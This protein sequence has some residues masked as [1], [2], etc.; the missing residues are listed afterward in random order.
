L[1][2]RGGSKERKGGREGGREGDILY[3][4]FLFT[5][6]GGGRCGKEGRRVMGREGEGGEVG[7]REGIRGSCT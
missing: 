4:C 5:C 1:L 6:H 3:V 2:G 7:R